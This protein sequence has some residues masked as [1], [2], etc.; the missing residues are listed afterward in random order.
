MTSPG[1]AGAAGADCFRRRFAGLGGGVISAR[2]GRSGSSTTLACVTPSRMLRTHDGER[3]KRPVRSATPYPDAPMCVREETAEYYI[4]RPSRSGPLPRPP[5]VVA[6]WGWRRYDR[7]PGVMARPGSRSQGR[8][9]PSPSAPPIARGC[10]LLPAAGAGRI[11]RNQLSQGPRPAFSRV[12]G[13][14][15]DGSRLAPAWPVGP[16]WPALPA[17]EVW[18]GGGPP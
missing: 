17:S 5:W 4:K 11:A 13:P 18:P 9:A 6:R 10:R 2:R 14:S 16:T 1:R 8:S 3:L 7:P 15:W 12:R